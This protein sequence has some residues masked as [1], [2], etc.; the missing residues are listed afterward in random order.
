MAVKPT[1]YFILKKNQED[2]KPP[3]RFNFAISEKYF[4]QVFG[5]IYGSRKLLSSFF[6]IIL[7]AGI[8]HLIFHF[9]KVV[10]LQFKGV[11]NNNPNL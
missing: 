4:L 8:Q 3:I 1:L 11:Q 10:I 7:L 2:S 5:D 6:R 9:K